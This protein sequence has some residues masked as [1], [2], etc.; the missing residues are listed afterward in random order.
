MKKNLLTTKRIRPAIGVNDISPFIPEWWANETLAILYEEMIAAKL[1]N[2]NFEK[3]FNKFGDVVNIGR[4]REF[5]GIRKVKGEAVTTQ[6]AIVDNIQITLDQWCHVSFIIDD[7]DNTMSMKMLS[8]QFARPAGQALARMIDRVVLGQ[9][10]RFLDNAVGKLNG[11]TEDNI[12][13]YLVDL[14][15]EMDTNKAHDSERNL[16]LS[17]RTKG[18]LLKPDWMTDVDRSGESGAL[19]RA[20]LG[21]IFGFRVHKDINMATVT[22]GNTTKVGAINLAAG[23]PVGTTTL[24]VDG[25]TGALTNFQWIELDGYPYQVLSHTETTSNTTGIVLTS[26]L[27][28]ATLDNAVVTGYTA[29]AI[30]NASGYAL[31]WTKPLAIDGFTVAPRVGQFVTFGSDTVNRY[32]IIKASTTAIT[33]DRKL[34]VALVD[35]ATV[36]IGPAGAYNLCIH[37]DAITLAIRPLAPVQPGTGAK[38]ATIN[39]NG[40]TIRVTISYDPSIQQH[41]WTLDFLAG[42]QVLDVNLGAVLLG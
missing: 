3:Y 2:R 35:D 23:Y 21:N 6:D 20:T 15:T 9:Y 39:W 29:G 22:T 13:G 42:I 16:I 8:D 26:G 33:L 40:L 38:S 18:D 11:I 12:K 4:P 30:N 25:F 10:P 14:S 24:V 19:R 36:N 41:R 34:E 31:G 27:V 7:A 32:T 28:R 17:S 1:V 37:P 5:E